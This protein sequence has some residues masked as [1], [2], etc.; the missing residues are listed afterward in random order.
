[1][2]SDHLILGNRIPY[3]YFITWGTGE[4]DVSIHAGAYDDALKAANIE[5]C[6]IIKYSSVM[7]PEAR[8]APMPDKM[9]HGCV[10]ETI[11]SEMSGNQGEILTAGLITWKIKR[12]DTGELV[13]GFVA[14]YNGHAAEATARQ[15]LEAAMEG[16]NDRR[17]YARDRF[18][19]FDIH[20][21]IKS[22][23]PRKQFGTVMVVIG[24]TSY[25]YPVLER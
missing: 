17:G 18:E 11:L 24:F 23:A 15:N 25:I 1:V 13:G 12:K 6:N 19:T 14:E 3:E 20:L 16:M 21:E 10:L 2:T 8:L 9:R 22:F 5:N 7:P 4:S